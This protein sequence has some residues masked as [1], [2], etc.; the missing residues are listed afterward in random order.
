MS[1][2]ESG[3]GAG[4]RIPRQGV[5]GSPV[6]SWLTIG[7]AV[8]AVIVGFLILRTITDNDSS[9]S[10][11]P[12]TEASDTSGDPTAPSVPIEVPTED[13]TTTT[14][15][16]A[17]VTEGSAVIVAN[18]NSVGGSAGDMSTTLEGAGYTVVDPTDAS[19]SAVETSLVYFDAA[20]PGAEDIANSVARDLGGL[21]VAPVATPAPTENGDLGDAGVL[22]VLGDAEAG[23]SIEELSGAPAGEAT[24]AAPDPAGGDS[25]DSTPATG[26]VDDG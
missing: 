20:I 4:R 24:E 6:G 9:A 15:T 8:I 14:S 7:L 10:D 1:N 11:D 25:T 21:E 16:I 19:G 17:R 26:E 5:G 12:T 22:V 3:F 23:R 13:S 18:A 2:E